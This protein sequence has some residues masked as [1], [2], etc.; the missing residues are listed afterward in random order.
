MNSFYK[1]FIL[2]ALPMAFQNLV[3]TSVSLIDNL[4]I[5]RLGDV[6]IASVGLANKVF[7]IY[8]LVIFGLCSGASAFI[9]QFWGKEDLK[10]IKQVVFINTLVALSVSFVFAIFG[11]FMPTTIMTLLTDDKEVIYEGAKYLKIISPSFI[12]VSII[13]V[14]SYTLKTLEHPKIPLFASLISIIINAFLNYILIFGKLGAPRLGVSGAAFATL[15][16]RIFE[17]LF[18]VLATKKK[19]DFLF[20][21][22]SH[23]KDIKKDFLKS[24]FIKVIPVILNET[25][26]SLATTMMVSIYARISTQAVAAVNV[27]TILRDL[28]SVFFIGAG[29]AAAVSIGKLIGLKKYDEAYERTYQLSIYVPIFAGIFGLLTL[30]VSKNFIGLFN[31]SV[32]TFNIANSLYITA[33]IFMPFASFN[34]LNICGSLRAGGDSFYCLVS[35]AGSIWAV[36]VFGSFISGTVFG[37]PILYVYIISRCEEILKAILLFIRI[38]KRKWIKDLVN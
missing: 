3:T 35:D 38:K 15:S 29:N 7:F 36:G 19:L 16:A 22:I 8:V 6:A 13:H 25:M 33:V 21:G 37:L 30:L 10:G 27:I 28:T 5:G 2:I 18:I 4:M 11:F 14:C 12:L 34:H 24:F 23:L 20:Y 31:I 26:W 17:M 1:N 9:A 32:E